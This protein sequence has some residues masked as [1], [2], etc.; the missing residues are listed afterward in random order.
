MKKLLFIDLDGTLMDQDKRVSDENACAIKEAMDKGNIVAICSGRSING[1][2][3]ALNQLPMHENLYQIGYH[4]GFI[5]HVKNN[6]LIYKNPM[7]EEQVKTISRKATKENIF[8][9]CFSDDCIFVP[10]ENETF[11]TYINKVKEKYYVFNDP[12]EIF[13]MKKPIFKVMLVD[14]SNYKKLLEFNSLFRKVEE[15]I[16]A[17]SFFSSTTYLE[18][19]KKG[20]SKGESLK[21]L[22]KYLNEDIKNTI[23]VGDER[24]D[25]SLIKEANIGCAMKNARDELK[26]VADYITKNDYNN[27]GVAEIIDKFV[28]QK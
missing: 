13:D 18:Y 23:A 10:N 28:L 3:Y 19:V 12:K 21:I 22:T 9:I 20:I 5:R 7:E 14:F 16:G 27:S 2:K 17:K 15:D 6:E 1:G 25:I 4:G 24:N 11:K 8:H 26:E